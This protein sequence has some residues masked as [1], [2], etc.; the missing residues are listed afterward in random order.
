[1]STIAVGVVGYNQLGKRVA[2]WTSRQAD[3]RLAAVVEGDPHLRD[4]LASRNMPVGEADPATWPSSPDVVVVCRDVR[5]L[6][7]TTER[8]VWLHGAQGSGSWYC[9]NHH[10][11]RARRLRIPCPD[12]VALNRVLAQLPE[13]NRVFSSCARRVDYEQQAGMVDSLEPIFALPDEDEQLQQLLPAAKSVMVRRTFLPY[14]HS[15]VHHLKLDFRRP[16]TRDTA[17]AALRRSERIRLVAGSEGFGNTGR[18]QQFDRD[19]GRPRGDRPEIVIWQE[20]VE[21]CGDSL[22]L[23]LDVAPEATVLP[24]LFD[25]MRWSMHDGMTWQTA[26]RMTNL[27]L[28]LRGSS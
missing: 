24:E 14:T 9:A 23:T 26:V 13:V 1:M 10:P 21:V 20:T 15:H 19:C 5:G 2:D 28:D 17:L 4:Q 12:V 22:M 11:D 7:L 6:K 16:L 3:L 8:C 25:A 18:V 27:A